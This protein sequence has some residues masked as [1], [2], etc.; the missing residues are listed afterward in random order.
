MA[1]LHEKRARG[2]DLQSGKKGIGEK[3]LDSLKWIES[4]QIRIT[5]DN[6]SGATADREFQEF[7]ILMVT[8]NFEP[9]IHIHPESLACQSCK[10]NPDVFLVE[11]PSK[12]FPAQDFIK[13]GEDRRR[14][15]QFTF[16][17]R[18]ID[19]FAWNGI[20]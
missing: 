11:V 18:S 14:K 15:Q 10:K 16:T 17:E 5:G 12:A 20:R 2:N 4:K 6:V 1:M 19:G 7:V 9:Y 13:F 3:N 8:T